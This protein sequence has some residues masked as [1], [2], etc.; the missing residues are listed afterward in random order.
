[1]SRSEG[2]HMPKETEKELRSLP[3]N[4]RC[5]D[6]NTPGPQWASVS[7][8]VFMC[9]EC[10]GRHRGLGVHISFVRSVS[11]DAWKDREVR[12][13]QVG[14]NGKLIA[15]FKAYGVNSLPIQA[16]YNTPA[17]AMYRDI[18]SALK[19]G[20]APPTDI[21]PYIEEEEKEK[22]DMAARAS[23][24]GGSSSMGSMSGGGGG[25][26]SQADREAAAA[27]AKAEASE[28]IRAKFGDGGLKGQSVSNN[29][30]G[31]VSNNPSSND[32][33]LDAAAL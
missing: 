1:M 31:S 13:M 29:P 11:M 21:Q 16:K 20:R 18:I 4:D 28:R 12:A 19:E 33:G 26:S 15:H 32:D 27:R 10:S 14:G 9:L 2:H 30:Y 17:A 7:Y 5:V 22:A 6:C 24:S 25:G 23:G 8:G 3:G